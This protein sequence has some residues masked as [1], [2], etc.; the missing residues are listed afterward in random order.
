MKDLRLLLYGILIG[1][2]AT[3]AIL[4][5]SQPGRGVPIALSPAP[6]ATQTSLPK[7]TATTSPIQVQVGG[8]VNNPGIYFVENYTRL[9]DLITLAGGLTHQAD[10][11]R[12][13]L[14]LLLR[15]GDYI[16]MPA[17]NEIIPETARNAPGNSY[18]GNENEFDYP[19]NLNQAS[20]EALESLPGIGPAKA[21]DILTYRDSIGSFSS[22]D[23][24]L[25]VIG[26]GPTILET[27]R[28]YL[29]IVP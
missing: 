24:L 8:E 1:L 21:V 6:S 2:L 28:D 15:D 27:L 25:N 22:V 16:Y 13:N 29:V 20:Q 14:V 12:I 23:E 3:G 4:L 11:N 5:I 7:P 26:I 19:L 10:H 9:G 17:A 18:L